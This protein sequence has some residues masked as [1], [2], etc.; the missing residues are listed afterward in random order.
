LGFGDEYN[1]KGSKIWGLVKRFY[2]RNFLRFEKGD[3]Y[4]MIVEFGVGRVSFREVWDYDGKRLIL[5]KVEG[6]DGRDRQNCK[7]YFEEDIFIMEEDFNKVKE[8]V[9]KGAGNVL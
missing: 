5:K 2:L 3:K 9:V 6:Y 1:L 8:V 7:C 4:K